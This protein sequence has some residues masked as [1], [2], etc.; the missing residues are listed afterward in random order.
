MITNALRST[1]LAGFP[2]GTPLV[3]AAADSAAYAEVLSARADPAVLLL[4][5][6]DV[7]AGDERLAAA[8]NVLLEGLDAA[9]D[10]VALLTS[11]RAGAPLARVFALVANAA[12]VRGLAAA[13]AGSFPG[14]HPLVRAELE[15]LFIAAGWTPLAVTPIADP[16][17]V[18]PHAPPFVFALGSITIGVDD[19]EIAERSTVAAYVVVA[20]RA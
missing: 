9:E 10:P 11:L 1:V 16:T 13:F 12:H 19:G 4:S 5:F 14:G 20:D 3:V 18:L 7:A 15:P 6:D 8:Q 17:I 2:H